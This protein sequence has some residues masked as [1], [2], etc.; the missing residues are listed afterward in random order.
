[1]GWVRRPVPAGVA[2]L[3]DRAYALDG[4]L[5]SAWEF[6][7]RGTS[8]RAQAVQVAEAERLLAE[9]DPRDVVPR[10]APVLWHAGLAMTAAAGTMLG[11]ALWGAGPERIAVEIAP[12]QSLPQPAARAE[13][14]WLPAPAAELP[15]DFVPTGP[16]SG[17]PSVHVPSTHEPLPTIPP[18]YAPVVRRYVAD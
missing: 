17:S 10:R 18:A 1:M 16:S 3:L 4:R 6:T 14:D 15:A 7:S 2:D 8:T 5:R 13:V 9:I 12:P 11:T